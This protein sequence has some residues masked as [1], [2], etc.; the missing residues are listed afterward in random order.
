M[1]T[2]L[3]LLLLFFSQIFFCQTI[4]ELNKKRDE[5]NRE[6]NSLEYKLHEI[7]VELDHIEGLIDITHLKNTSIESK[8]KRSGSIYENTNRYS[9]KLAD[10][11]RDTKIYVIE[12]DANNKYFKVVYNNKIG[13]I[14]ANDV[15]T[16]KALKEK[17]RNTYRSK[18]AK[19]YSSFKSTSSRRYIRGPRGGCYYIN[20]NGNKTYVSRSLCN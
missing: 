3:T 9:S 10:T 7:S 11:K 5:L 12:Y 19:Y 2:K 18:K 1:K 17:K 14:P 4:Q 20:S 16:N 15:K 6:K 8:I 13:Y